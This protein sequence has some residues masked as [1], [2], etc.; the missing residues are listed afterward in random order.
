M[1]HKKNAIPLT[2]IT[3]WRIKNIQGIFS[4]LLRLNE[5]YTLQA[6]SCQE[7]KHPLMRSAA[8]SAP[9]ALSLQT[10][11]NLW[12]RYIFMENVS[13]FDY[14]SESGKKGQVVVSVY[15]NPL[16]DDDSSYA[17]VERNTSKPKE[18]I[19]TV[20]EKGNVNLDTA[21]LHYAGTLFKEACIKLLKQGYAINL[22]DMGILYLTVNGSIK[23]KKPTAADIPELKIGFSPSSFAKNAVKD[24]DIQLKLYPDNTPYIAQVFDFGKKEITNELTASGVIEIHGTSL[25]LG[26]EGSGVWLAPITNDEGDYDPKNM[27]PVTD[28]I[29]NL[30]GKLTVQL[31]DGLEAGK[32]YRIVIRTLLTKNSNKPGKTV[33]TGVYDEAVSIGSGGS[34]D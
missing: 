26:G 18:L 13:N 28:I 8:W 5:K 4:G 14:K 21:T 16:T 9:H 22:F 20:E 17:R 15:K 30:P 24:V 2:L 27:I 33:K 12:T 31:P 32:D 10:K 11:N 6:A 19:G 34:S 3:K 1:A 29:H 23:T 25:K 7:Q